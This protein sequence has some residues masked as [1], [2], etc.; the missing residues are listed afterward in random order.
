MEIPK[1]LKVVSI[2]VIILGAIRLIVGAIAFLAIKEQSL[3]TQII[4]E[5]FVTGI[6]VLASGLL[7][8]KGKSIGR[9]IL[10]VAGLVSWGSNYFI[11]GD[12]GIGT[13]VIFGVL[14]ALLFLED[15][16]KGFFSKS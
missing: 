13:L 1:S 16:I 12:L 14:I 11:S 8:I 7:L 4:L 15:N 6:L 3:L 9:I 10:I 2:I 5:N